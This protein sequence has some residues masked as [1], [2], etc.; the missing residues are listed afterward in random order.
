MAIRILGTCTLAVL[1]LIVFSTGAAEP[2]ATADKPPAAQ[3]PT[4]PD[5]PAVAAI[6]QTKPT[7]PS[8]CLR[9]AKI[10]SEL[11]RPDLAKPFLKKVLDAKLDRPAL[12]RLAEELGPATCI[13]IGQHEDLR[14][15]GKQVA[16]ALQDAL[17]AELRDPQRISALIAQLQNP[18]AEKRDAAVTGLV[19]ARQAAITAIVTVLADPKRA[20]EHPRLRAILPLFGRDAV[21]PLLGVLENADPALKAQVIIALEPMAFPEVKLFLLEPAFDSS[22]EPAV[23]T[24]AHNTLRQI[25]GGM[26]DRR[27]AIVLLTE[28]AQNYFNR[29]ERIPGE[30]GGW[31]EIGRWDTEKKHCEITPLSEDDAART[32]AARL[33]SGAYRLAPD[34]PKARQ[35]YLITLLEAAAYRQGFDRPI[36][37]N[38][39]AMRTAGGF[40]WQAV[41]EALAG[42]LTTGHPGAAA[43]AAGILGRIGS[44]EHLYQSAVPTPLARAVQSPDRRVRLAAVRSIATLNPNRPYAGSSAVPDALA[45]FV[46]TRGTR[47]ALIAGPNTQD[48]QR[49][50]SGL[51]AG[52]YQTDLAG[53]GREVMRLLTAS[54]DYELVL[55]DAGIDR[56]PVEQLMQQIRHDNR[57]ADLRVGVLTRAG[58]SD[59][60]RNTVAAD[61]MAKTFSPPH[62]DQAIQWQLAQLYQLKP[63]DFLGQKERLLQA[64]EAMEIMVKLSR[65]AGKLYDFRRALPA[66]LISLE[67]PA[68]AL[69]AIDVLANLNMPE[70]QRALVETADRN[71]VAV[72]IRQAAVVALRWNIQAHG[73]LLTIEEIRRQYDRYNQ[74]EKADADTQ[75]ILGEILDCF[76]KPKKK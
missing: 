33:S 72:P 69:K 59:R 22:S 8:E 37:E 6:L 36:D 2:A 55:V 25:A 30:I 32:L 42:A 44:A 56:P 10:F 26:P 63:H 51:A 60:A 50:I 21:W 76:E 52:G 41:N 70:A 23:R 20:E 15:E 18:S 67:S 53:S 14:P 46:A 16:D 49:L 71:T 19:R 75:K 13:S 5:N 43:T 40:G 74:S 38:D 64:S 62:D 1:F 73:I 4:L 35:L 3:E 27:E 47:H 57:S 24:A 7:T 65:S 45:F 17:N 61:S 48:N 58:F 12:A 68:L 54:P 11:E 9:A 28:A 31:L 29:G 34:D 39:V 66:V